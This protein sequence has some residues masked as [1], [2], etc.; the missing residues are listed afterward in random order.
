M[1]TIDETND[2]IRAR[3]NAELP[4]PAGGVETAEAEE[5]WRDAHEKRFLELCAESVNETK[6]TPGPRAVKWEADGNGVF[7]GTKCIATTHRE[8]AKVRHADA[9]LLAAAPELLE[10]L[11]LALA[12][13]QTAYIESNRTGHGSE[14]AR[15]FLLARAAIAKAK[16]TR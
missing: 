14:A 8:P 12:P 3:V 5:A 15:A 7:E 6:H 13:L 2:E 9:V 11:E 10:A 1:K 16:G 4:R